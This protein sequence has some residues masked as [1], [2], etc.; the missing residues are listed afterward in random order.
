M[1]TE[2]MSEGPHGAPCTMVRGHI[3]S[4]RDCAGYHWRPLAAPAA[5]VLMQSAPRWWTVDVTVGGVRRYLNVGV[6]SRR[7]AMALATDWLEMD[8]AR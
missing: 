4:H 3:G 2:C 6:P 5:I 1:A 8:N 7:E